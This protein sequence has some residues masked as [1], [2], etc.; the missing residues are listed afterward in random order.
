MISKPSPYRRRLLCMSHVSV[1]RCGMCCVMCADA[2]TMCTPGYILTGNIGWGRYTPGVYLLTHAPLCRTCDVDCERSCN[3]DV[4]PVADIC[5]T[6]GC[7]RS[8]TA[9]CSTAARVAVEVV[10]SIHWLMKPPRLM[11]LQSYNAKHVSHYNVCLLY[12]SPSPRDVEESR[13]PSS[14]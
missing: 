8:C 3:A 10:Q 13:M 5:D 14:A 1:V 2:Y 6:G 12:T 4:V 9:G 11:S 7:R